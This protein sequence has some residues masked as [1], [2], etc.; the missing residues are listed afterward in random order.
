MDWSVIRHSFIDELEK[1]AEFNLSGLS[2][3]NV[4]KG[5]TPPPPME[6]VGFSKARDILGRAQMTK[7]SGTKQVKRMLPTNPAIGK[8]THQGDDSSSEKAKSVAGYGLAGLGASKAIHGLGASMPSVY[9]ATEHP[10]LDPH[11]RFANKARL[12]A[13]GHGMMLGG[14]AL[15]LGYGIHRQ[16][17]KAKQRA[18]EMSKTSMTPGTS[19]KASQ[20]M[21]K[22]IN[23]V[24]AG[25]SL[26]TQTPGRI[27]SKGG[28]P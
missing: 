14:T 24:K 6:T 1:I 20:Q 22:P 27:G 18:A 9:H 7:E 10:S 13:V 3:E 16:R 4:M 17:V 2:P 25:P 28:I 19:L 23:K 5:S 8:L 12:N 26:K 21:A 15:G 11:V